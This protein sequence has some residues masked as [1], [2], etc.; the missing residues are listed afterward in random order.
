MHSDT[1]KNLRRNLIPIFITLVPVLLVMFVIYGFSAQ[2][3]DVS[4]ETS[5]GITDLVIELLV[6]DYEDLPLEK[7]ESLSGQITY[8]VRK[9][10]HF[11]E[12]ALLGFFLILHFQMIHNVRPFRCRRISALALCVL[13][14]ASD[15]FH[16]A[17][18]DGRSPSPKDVLIDSAGA[19]FGILIMT[20]IISLCIKL[21]RR[22]KQAN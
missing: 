3:S 8:I 1:P 4:S 9:T 14:A 19:L 18:V 5:G 17:F 10:G 21:K 20:L 11:S 15:E 7:Q 12:F 6:P 22:K 16:Q 2:D 13:Y